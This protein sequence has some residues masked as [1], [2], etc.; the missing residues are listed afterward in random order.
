VNPATL[1]SLRSRLGPKTA[2][3]LRSFRRNPTANPT[4]PPCLHRQ[5]AWQRRQ[6]M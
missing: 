3:P 4:P 5:S 1:D 6:S 2:H